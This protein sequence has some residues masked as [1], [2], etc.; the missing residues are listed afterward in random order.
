MSQLDKKNYGQV[1]ADAAFEPSVRNGS[2]FRNSYNRIA[3]AVFNSTT[4]LTGKAI[5]KL[6]G[7]SSVN[8]RIFEM[9]QAGF[10]FKK[11]TVNV[12]GTAQ[13]AYSL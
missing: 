9:E 2:K 5:A 10:S 12:D 6:V 1:M 11:S 8:T 13:T 4:A 7:I 3:A